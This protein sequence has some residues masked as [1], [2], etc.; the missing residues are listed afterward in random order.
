[1]S[2]RGCNRLREKCSHAAANLTKIECAVRNGYTV[3]TSSQCSWN[4]VVQ[5]KKVLCAHAVQLLSCWQFFMWHDPAKVIDIDFSQPKA[6]SGPLLPLRTAWRTYKRSSLHWSSTFKNGGY[7]LPPDHEDYFQIQGLMGIIEEPYCDFICWTLV[8][9]HQEQI[10][11][12]QALFRRMITKLHCCFF[13]LVILFWVLS[14]L[15]KK[16]TP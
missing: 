9:I 5:Q 4:Q 15:K 10:K 11:L 8:G 14:G 13:V 12:D 1:M 7:I 3:T 2:K 6:C 16:C